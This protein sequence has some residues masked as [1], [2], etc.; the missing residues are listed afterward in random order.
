MSMSGRDIRDLYFGYR[1]VASHMPDCSLLNSDTWEV[2]RHTWENFDGSKVET[3]VRLA[4]HECG[5]ITFMKFD[6]EASCRSTSASAVGYG[7]RPERAGG[8]WLHPG[9]RYDFWAERGPTAYY[10][11]RTK[12]RPREPGDVAGIVGWGTGPRGG[13]RWEAG[14]GC[15]E[16]GSV[17]HG[18]GRHFTSRR[19]AVAWI[20]AQLAPEPEAATCGARPYP[21]G[22]E[23]DDGTECTLPPHDDGQ[24]DDTAAEPEPGQLIILPVG[25]AGPGSGTCSCGDEAG[26]HNVTN[27]ANLASRFPCLRLGCGCQ[28][29]DPLSIR[30]ATR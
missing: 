19:A 10:V 11:T 23:G 18:A 3:T 30:K 5:S 7:S 8:L 9:P 28:D 20:A 29:Y 2:T 22:S 12:E 6:E 16:Y 25:A 26:E 1:P 17:E 24:H 14:T 21:A 13:V 15:T 4:C 27:I